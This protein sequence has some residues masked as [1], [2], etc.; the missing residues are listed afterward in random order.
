VARF[1]APVQTGPGA[2]PAFC[3]VGTGSLSRGLTNHLPS[4]AEVNERVELY[5]HSPSVFTLC[6]RVNFTFTLYLYTLPLH[7][8]FTLYL[9]TLPLHFTIT[10]YHYTLPLH[11]TTNRVA[12]VQSLRC[13]TLTELGHC[14]LHFCLVTCSHYC[15]TLE[16]KGTHCQQKRYLLKLVR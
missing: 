11:F 15:Q 2:H 10:L 7:F 4:R 3:T 14:Q 13:A 1:S 12:E 16:K 5:H 8:T 9:Y 6:C